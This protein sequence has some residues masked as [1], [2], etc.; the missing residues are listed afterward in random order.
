MSDLLAIVGPA[1]TDEELLEEIARR[2]PNR[3]TVLVED[4]TADLAADDSRTSHALRDRLASLM[5]AIERRTGAAVV[6]LAGSRDQLEGWR[7]DR[8]VG[9]TE[10]P[11]AV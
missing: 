9:R 2:R 11:L 10:Q 3:V 6:G 4:A 7:F 5:S 1:E 8:I